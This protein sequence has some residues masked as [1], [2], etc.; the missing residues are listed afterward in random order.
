MCLYY[1]DTVC[2][3]G[4]ENPSGQELDLDAG[5]SES[6]WLH[7]PATLHLLSY[8]PDGP[9]SPSRDSV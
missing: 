9:G 2:L 4:R 3:A 6:P 1:Q 7:S 8:R 5:S